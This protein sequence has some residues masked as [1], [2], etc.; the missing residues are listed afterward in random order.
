MAL[1][2]RL[3]LNRTSARSSLWMAG[4]A[5]VLK[6]TSSFRDRFRYISK[7]RHNAHLRRTA[8]TAVAARMARPLHA[9][10]K[11]GEPYR[12]LFEGPS[13]GGRASLFVAAVG[14]VF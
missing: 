6:H 7:D 14:A 8:Y 3:W 4:Q 1:L 5:A 13:R 10:I 12:P 9:V 2:A 11:R